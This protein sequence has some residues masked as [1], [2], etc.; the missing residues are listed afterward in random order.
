M[1]R[2]LTI[3][4]FFS[5]LLSFLV[6]SC[7]SNQASTE[8]ENQIEIASIEGV[9]ATGYA[10][11]DAKW[12]IFDQ[13]ERV[14]E[15]GSTNAA[16]EFKASVSL[17]KNDSLL[18]PLLIQV[19]KEEDT[20]YSFVSFQDVFNLENDSSVFILVNPMTNVVTHY[21]LSQEDFS[22]TNKVREEFNR[23][24][25]NQL[26]YKSLWFSSEYK[27]AIKGDINVKPSYHDVLIHSLGE[28]AHRSKIPF[29]LLL[30][31]II[32]TKEQLDYSNELAFT[33]ARFG[34][35]E[36][37]LNFLFSDLGYSDRVSQYLLQNAKAFQKV[38]PLQNVY[39]TGPYAEK[40]RAIAIRAMGYSLPALHARYQGEQ[41]QKAENNRNWTTNLFLRIISDELLAIQSKLDSVLLEDALDI[42]VQGFS[43]D[44]IAILSSIQ[45]EEWQLGQN[46]LNRIVSYVVHKNVTENNNINLVFSDSAEYRLLSQEQIDALILEYMKANPKDTISSF[47]KGKQNANLN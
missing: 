31:S 25:F 4:I 11:S 23:Q 22:E 8:V 28:V 32:I 34:L 27:A 21:L 9:V 35:A 37:N 46:K 47:L 36:D 18:F 12:T 5:L 14:I 13:E 3:K 29:S 6:L 24:I 41:R 10:F 45:V 43:I 39:F 30:D 26:D 17:S 1:M 38:L 44:V 40:I 2:L 7:S 20:L 42:Y 16:G 33:L 15:E 19:T